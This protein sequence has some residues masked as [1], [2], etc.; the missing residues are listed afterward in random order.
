M[1][2]A[3]KKRKKRKNG[4]CARVRQIMDSE[5]GLDHRGSTLGN[6]ILDRRLTS[7][8]RIP[9]VVATYLQSRLAFGLSRLGSKRLTIFFHHHS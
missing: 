6:S 1:M 7:Y 4:F 8:S 3:M 2:Y 5:R 9:L